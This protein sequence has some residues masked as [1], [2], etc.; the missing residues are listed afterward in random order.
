MLG[1]M[2]CGGSGNGIEVFYCQIMNTRG[3]EVQCDLI[4]ITILTLSEIEEFIL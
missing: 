3:I 1:D 4:D 2:K